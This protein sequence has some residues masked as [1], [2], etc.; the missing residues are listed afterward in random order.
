MIKLGIEGNFFNL[1]KNICQK[2]TANIILSGV[3]LNAFL[4]ILGKRQRGQFLSLLYNTVLEVQASEVR[5][6]N[7][8]H[9]DQKET[10]LPG[11]KMT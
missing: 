10:K 3:R 8:R 2:P 5:K 1:I 9:T 11:L 6:G 4:L 7:K